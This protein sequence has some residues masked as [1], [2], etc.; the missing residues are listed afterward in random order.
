MKI[1]KLNI[2]FIQ[3]EKMQQFLGKKKGNEQSLY[4]I[5]EIEQNTKNNQQFKFQYKKIQ[6]KNNKNYE[7]FHI[8]LKEK[9]FIYFCLKCDEKS[10]ISINYVSN[11]TDLK[12]KTDYNFFEA[13]KDDYLSVILN[14]DGEIVISNLCKKIKE[15][16]IIENKKS[17]G[18][19]VFAIEKG[20]VTFL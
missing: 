3:I 7:T 18:F 9:K 2:I 13:E 12:K 10:S 5:K 4:Q 1:N 16:K 15:I 8:E 20:S 17:Y 11:K 19:L 6:N 14:E